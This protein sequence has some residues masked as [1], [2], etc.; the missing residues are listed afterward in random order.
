MAANT[1][2]NSFHIP[3]YQPDPRTPPPRAHVSGPVTKTAEPP[4]FLLEIDVSKWVN[5]AAH[6][7]QKHKSFLLSSYLPSREDGALYETEGDVV[8]E[9]ILQLNHPVH[10][11]LRREFP[12]ARH[13]SEVYSAASTARA[14]K[15]YYRQ[16]QLQT[17]TRNF[18]ALEYKNVA[19]IDG[20]QFRGGI[21]RDEASFNT[22]I[23]NNRTRRF[24]PASSAQ[25]LLK[26]AVNYSHA[27]NTPFV[28]LF[29]MRT[30]ILLVFPIRRGLKAGHYALVTVV[31]DPRQ[32]RKALLGFLL[33]ASRHLDMTSDQC[34]NA[35]LSEELRRWI[36]LRAA[37]VAAHLSSPAGVGGRRSH[38]IAALGM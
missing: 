2:Y 23:E 18:A 35:I 7:L 25:I 20:D 24:R 19:V 4:Y 34:K 30:L 28:A 17:A 14:D 11:A 21:V 29:D 12:T 13:G 5:M 8:A 32:M 37:R 3:I 22:M 36:D 15:V 16:N 33:M 26:Q 1:I 38:R 31:E 27:Y 10:Q 9:S 6:I